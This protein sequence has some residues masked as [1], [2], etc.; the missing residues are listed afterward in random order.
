MP[1]PV[2]VCD[3]ECYPNYWSIQLREVHGQQRTKVFER[4]IDKPLDIESVARILRHHTIVTFNGIAYD[5]QMIALALS[6]A[7]N[8]LLKEASNTLINKQIMWWEFY[9]QYGVESPVYIDAIDLWHVSPGSPTFPSLKLYAGRMHSRRMQD[10]PFPH[11]TVLTPEQMNTLRVYG[12]NDLD[13]TRDL[14]L[15]LLPQITLRT[16]MSQRYRIDLR[17]KSDAQVA[18]AVVKAEV[19]KRTGQRIYKPEIEKETLFSYKAPEYI[20]FNTPVLQDLLDTFE[21]GT[22]KVDRS[23]KFHPPEVLKK[24]VVLNIGEMRYHAGYG[25][26]HSQE[27]SVWCIADEHHVIVD[28]DATSYYAA[29][30]MGSAIYPK[31][32]GPVFLDIYREIYKERLDAKR[33]G[34]KDTAESLKVTILGIIGKFGSMYSAVFSP[35]LLMQVTLTGQLAIL[36]LIERIE[37]A[38]MRVLSANTDGVVTNVPWARRDVFD[39]IVAQWELDTIFTTEAAEYNAIYSRDVNNYFAIKAD[40]E[41]K[42]KGMF[43]QSGLGLP[44]AAGL[45]K[46]PDREICIDAVIAHLKDGMPIE[47]TVR[48]CIDIRKFLEVRKVAGGAEKDGLLIGKALRWYWGKGEKGHLTYATKKG[49][50]V[51]SDNKVP[52]SRGAVPCMELPDTLPSDIDYEWYIKESYSIL[53]EVGFTVID[54]TFTGRTGEIRASLSGQKSVHIVNVVTGRTRCS[55]TSPSLRK[56]WVETTI[57]RPCR[58]C[59]KSNDQRT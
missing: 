9:A 33:R 42:R 59:E 13:V 11:G 39:R 27:K 38:G 17:S 32:I 2:C 50:R 41:V 36:M 43:A 26:L 29:L 55:R 58:K 54:P 8:M 25:G 7:T 37:M 21:S 6:G 56:S 5:N 44:G 16:K 51:K 15:E 30:I 31:N 28:T 45:K 20:C 4:L 47:Q 34:D 14:Y 57:G 1:R 49:D 3:T 18:E 12:L 10:L 48:A 22:F 40:G 53:Q 52:R 24:G 46:S 19:Y 35:D 23:G